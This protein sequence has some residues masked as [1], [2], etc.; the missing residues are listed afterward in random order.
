MRGTESHKHITA[1]LFSKPSYRHHHHQHHHKLARAPLNR[2]PAAPYV[3]HT[4]RKIKYIK[5]N[6]IKEK[7]NVSVESVQNS[8]QVSFFKDDGK[9][10]SASQ[11]SGYKLEVNSGKRAIREAC[12][13]VPQVRLST[14]QHVL[15]NAGFPCASF[16]IPASITYSLKPSDGAM[17]PP[18]QLQVVMPSSVEQRLQD[19]L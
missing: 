17:P 6:W 12:P 8:E 11:C 9:T 16:D 10:Q 1:D 18:S 14:F 13:P 19:V 5:W 2:W 3:Q 15:L 7:M 4:V